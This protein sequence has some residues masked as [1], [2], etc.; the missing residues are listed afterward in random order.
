[1]ERMPSIGGA[2]FAADATQ[3]HLD[4][5]LLKPACGDIGAAEMP[6]SARK[7]A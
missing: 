1:M 5:F 2:L 4:L 3:K 6:V 7:S